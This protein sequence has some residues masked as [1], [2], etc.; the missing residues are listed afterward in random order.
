MKYSFSKEK[1]KWAHVEWYE[2]LWYDQKGN[3]LTTRSSRKS[4]D[5]KRCFTKRGVI[6]WLLLFVW[7]IAKNQLIFFINLMQTLIFLVFSTGIRV[8]LKER[9]MTRNLI[10]LPDKEVRKT[11]KLRK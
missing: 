4:F 6:Q 2:K 9:N 7:I 5:L 11:N 8:Q 1:K 3:R 10:V